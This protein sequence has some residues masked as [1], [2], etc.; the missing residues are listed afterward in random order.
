LIGGSG[1]KKTLRLVARYADACNIFG[2]ADVV[3]QKVEVLRRHCDDVGRDPNEI[4][5]TAM[6]RDLPPGAS[7]AQVVEGAQRLAD[8]GVSTLVTSSV[9]DDP[10]GWLESTFG[11][12]MDELAAI[13]PT[14]L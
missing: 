12:A 4:E 7:V 14:R 10:A 13:E 11:P 6:Y 5:V 8:V 3:A 2:D 9:G 1:E